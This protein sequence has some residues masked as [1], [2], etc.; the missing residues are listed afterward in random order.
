MTIETSFFP[1]FQFFTSHPN[2]THTLQKFPKTT[3]I[4]AHFQNKP[5]KRKVQVFVKSHH[6][7]R[8]SYWTKT[9]LK[10]PFTQTLPYFFLISAL[11]SISTFKTKNLLMK[12]DTFDFKSLP[13]RFPPTTIPPTFILFLLTCFYIKEK[14]RKQSLPKEVCYEIKSNKI[15]H[16]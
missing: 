15:S 16:I 9:K 10:P 1:M 6:T 8:P 4:C 7:R 11:K 2:Q 12:P 13:H 3:R 14:L 5:Y